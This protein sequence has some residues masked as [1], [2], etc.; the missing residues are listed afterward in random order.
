MRKIWA[1]P[2]HISIIILHFVWGESWNFISIHLLLNFTVNPCLVWAMNNVYLVCFCNYMVYCG[3]VTH[4]HTPNWFFLYDCQSDGLFTPLSM[5]V[6]LNLA[7]LFAWALSFLCLYF[8][9]YS[10]RDIQA[11]LGVNKKKFPL[12]LYSACNFQERYSWTTSFGHCWNIC[13]M[14]LHHKLLQSHT[15]TCLPYWLTWIV[16]GLAVGMHQQSGRTSHCM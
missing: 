16:S 4:F 7:N 14:L 10:L 2:K 11:T 8:F 5:C 1:V 15:K 12:Y 9:F 6:K 13:T 3:W